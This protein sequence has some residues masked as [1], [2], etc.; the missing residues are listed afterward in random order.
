MRLTTWPS[1]EMRMLVGV[2]DEA[3]EL[4]GDVIIADKN[5]IVDGQLPSIDL[6]ALSLDER[7]NDTF[8]FLV[9]RH[10]EDD[11]TV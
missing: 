2:T 1:R 9:Q 10:A 11:K 5:L 8:A 4:I 6:E 7:G 3:S